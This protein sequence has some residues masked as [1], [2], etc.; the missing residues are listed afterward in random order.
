M[1]EQVVGEREDQRLRTEGLNFFAAVMAGQSHEVTNVLNII[2]EFAGLQGD[3]LRGE[4]QGRPMDIQKLKQVTE[5]IQNQV[6][7]GETIVRCMNQFAHSADCPVTVFDLKEALEQITYLMLR[8]ANLGKTALDQ[9]FPEDSIPL[10]TSPFGFKQAVFICIEIA[11]AASTEKRHVTVSYRVSDRGAEIATE[12]EDPICPGPSVT[13]KQ[14]FLSLLM[15][16]LGGE[17]VAPSAEVESRRLV[18]FFPRPAAVGDAS[19]TVPQDL[20]ATENFHAS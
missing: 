10:E 15:Q 20:A 19:V 7:R 11:L 1:K 18:L 3:I 9:K 2:H 13:E 17:F 4:E 8:S 16:E 6:R 5:R 12:S 14:A